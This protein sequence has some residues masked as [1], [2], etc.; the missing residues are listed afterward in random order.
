MRETQAD[1]TKSM[2]QYRTSHIK[3]EYAQTCNLIYES[4]LDKTDKYTQTNKL[5]L[6][7]NNLQ[8][9]ANQSNAV[10]SMQQ[11]I[12]VPTKQTHVHNVSPWYMKLTFNFETIIY[13]W[14][15]MYQ[16]QTTMQN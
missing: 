8:M 11:R 14:G 1:A 4:F 7:N 16:M 12:I 5:L 3:Q 15:Q 13:K 2:L 9:R 10:K 6:Q